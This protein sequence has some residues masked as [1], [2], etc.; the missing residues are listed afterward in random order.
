MQALTSWRR[1]AVVG[2]EAALAL[3][4][5]AHAGSLGRAARNAQHLMQYPCAGTLRSSTCS[6]CT[7]WSVIRWD[8]YWV[9]G[10]AGPSD[11]F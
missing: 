11:M 2:A 3:H 9:C 4:D 7:L 1:Y 5:E 6:S 8:A 10:R